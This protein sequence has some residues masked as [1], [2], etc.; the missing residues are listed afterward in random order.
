[1]LVVSRSVSVALQASVLRAASARHAHLAVPPPA[2][3]WPTVVR[4]GGYGPAGAPLPR[5]S[6]RAGAREGGCAQVQ[7]VIARWGGRPGLLAGVPPPFCV[8]H[9]AF[10]SPGAERSL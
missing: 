9:A 6:R 7:G 10:G 3:W 2:S 4:T 5:M 8:R 1:M